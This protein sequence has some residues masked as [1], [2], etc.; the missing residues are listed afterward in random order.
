MVNT[1][2]AVS[3]GIDIGAGDGGRPGAGTV[4]HRE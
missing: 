2:D 4:G 3:P 1:G